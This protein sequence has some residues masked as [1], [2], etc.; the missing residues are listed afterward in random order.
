MSVW[1]HLLRL[2]LTM[3]WLIV[4]ATS[5]FSAAAEENQDS[6]LRTG[7]NPHQLLFKVKRPDKASPLPSA[8]AFETKQSPEQ[9]IEDPLILSPHRLAPDVLDSIFPG[10]LAAETALEEASIQAS[11]GPV[12]LSP[13]RLPPE[14]LEAIFPTPPDLII[15]SDA[16]DEFAKEEVL[17]EEVLEEEVLAEETLEADVL[18][19]SQYEIPP[20]P[21]APENL[22]PSGTQ[23][24]LNRQSLNHLSNVEIQTGYQSS[25]DINS[26][27]HLQGTV[28]LE[29]RLQRSVTADRKITVEHKGTY[30]QSETITQSR[31]VAVARRLP[32]TLSGFGIQLSMTGTCLFQNTTVQE[33]CSYL[34]SLSTVDSENISDLTEAGRLQI[35]GEVGEVVTPES[36][37]A[38]ARPGFQ[39][40]ENGQA[41]GIDISFP[42]TGTSP[43]N[44]FSNNTTVDRRETSEIAPTFTLARRRQIVQMN[45][46]EA[47]L[48]VTV[49]GNTWIVGDDNSLLNGLVQAGAALLPDATPRL[50]GSQNPA[51]AQVNRNLFLAANNIRLPRDSFTLYHGGLGKATSIEAGMRPQDMPPAR[52]SGV[53]L[54]LSP[55][56]DYD[57]INRATSAT[58]G[59][60]RVTRTVGAEGKG[61]EGANL[62]LDAFVNGRDFTTENL[63]DTY[64]QIYQSIYE[65]DAES[66][67]LEN[68]TEKTTYYPHLSFTGNRTSFDN[69]FNYYA[70]VIVED[71]LNAYAGVDY[72]AF[73]T[74]GLTY[75][76]GGVV[77]TQPDRDYYS[78]IKGSIS[79]RFQL[80][81]RAT[82]SLASGFNWALDRSDQIGDVEVNSRS[83]VVYMKAIAQLGKFSLEASGN[84]GGILPNS[85]RDSVRIQAA[86][87][88]NKAI[89]LSGFITPLSKSSSYARYG[90]S[91]S[92]QVAASSN[93]PTLNAGWTNNRYGFG[94]DSFDN[95]VF[96]DE[97]LFVLS[98]QLSR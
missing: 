5:P 41:V 85:A 48:G 95:D 77:Y 30:F 35:D 68:Y 97:N 6:I 50:A 27:S 58:L 9:I 90:A 84:V 26:A 10:A 49:R 55:V 16:E 69:V 42:N 53:W 31:E 14:V 63:Q 22:S 17:E 39:R 54:G 23:F 45:D 86:V 37:S 56:K 92:W 1:P 87:A 79:K 80:S 65:T 57:I 71:D 36:L 11:A 12:I 20:H 74:N 46:R 89:A 70:G 62:R 52:F 91:L 19:P 81:R 76:A 29:S 18:E 98:L 21:L 47:A 83:S 13:H 43:G 3:C 75:N 82:I 32:Q 60:T 4:L 7:L 51:N 88:L 33:R 93:S 64:I 67:N 59:P 24:Q 38:I 25:N 44:Q 94:T 40:G 66:I 15:A 28:S 2:S 96:T 72:T 34:P 61:G 73:S 78:Q 8:F